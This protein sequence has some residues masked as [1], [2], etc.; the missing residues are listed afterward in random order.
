MSSVSCFGSPHGSLADA[1]SLIQRCMPDPA[2]G[3]SD[4]KSIVRPS[5]VTIGCQSFQAPMSSWITAGVTNPAT[6][7]FAT[8]IRYVGDALR[9]DVK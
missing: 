9:S 8:W 1:R 5:S 3:R 4:A 6:F 7:F 2:V